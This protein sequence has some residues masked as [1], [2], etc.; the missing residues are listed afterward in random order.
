VLGGDESAHAVHV[1]GVLLAELVLGTANELEL[2]E[3]HADVG[4]HLLDDEL[5]PLATQLQQLPVAL[6]VVQVGVQI[7]KQDRHMAASYRKKNRS[8]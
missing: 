5:V 1:H 6:Q 2:V 7:G 3:R 4:E 8:D